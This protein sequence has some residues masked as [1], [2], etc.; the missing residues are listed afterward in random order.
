MASLRRGKI[1]FELKGRR[2][3]GRWALIRMGNASTSKKHLWL[4]AKLADGD[5]GARR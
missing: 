4:L 3:R 5:G 1:T 2:M